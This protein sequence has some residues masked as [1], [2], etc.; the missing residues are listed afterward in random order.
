MSGFSTFDFSACGVSIGI[1]KEG[2]APFVE[3]PPPALLS[4]AEDVEGNDESLEGV[5]DM[6]VADAA[7]RIG[8]TEYAAALSASVKD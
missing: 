4:R 6:G 7:P 5:A 2:K 8:V 1:Q 3:T